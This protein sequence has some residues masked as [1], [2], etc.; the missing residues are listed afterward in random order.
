MDEWE[1]WFERVWEFR[2]EQLY[3]QLF[4]SSNTEGIYVL[5]FERFKERFRTDRVDPRWLHH[6]VLRFG[7]LKESGTQKFVTSG[8][9]N[10]WEGDR[11]VRR[12]SLALASSSC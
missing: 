10:S 3:P 9:S 11:P 7:S 12:A 4:G 5:S 2:E 6:G 8:L 1:E